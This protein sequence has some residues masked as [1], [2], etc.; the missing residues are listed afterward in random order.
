MAPEQ[1]AP[2]ATASAATVPAP[3]R[4][5]TMA[6]IADW[7]GI[8]RSSV[9]MMR[10]RWG[11]D[12][13]APFPAPDVELPSVGG[14]TVVLGWAWE[15][16]PAEFERW[17]QQRKKVPR[18]WS[19]TAARTTRPAPQP[20]TAPKPTSP[21]EPAPANAD[22]AEGPEPKEKIRTRDYIKPGRRTH[23]GTRQGRI[24]PG[25]ISRSVSRR[26]SRR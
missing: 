8:Q 7:W 2:S 6:H 22:A 19:S 12:S 11:P 21:H 20:G 26:G 10:K 5:F 14:G 17:D 16:W 3:M 4:C 9:T 23:S 15:R 18:R 25:R 1:E 24:A 13:A